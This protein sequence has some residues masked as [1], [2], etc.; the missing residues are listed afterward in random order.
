MIDFSK[1]PRLKTLCVD[2]RSFYASCAAV[3]LGLDPL[4][5]HLAVVSDTQRQGSVVLAASP[6]MKRDFRIKTGSRLFEIPKDPR[7]KVVNASMESFLKTSVGITK[8]LNTFAPR[9]DIHVYSVDEA[10]CVMENNHL[11]GT[12]DEAAKK[13]QDQILKVYG[14]PS[15]IGIGDNMLQSK[16]CLDL[17]SKKSSS[18]IASWTYED[19]PKKLWPVEP[20]SEM[21]G[22]GSRLERRLNRMGIFSVGRLAN[23]PIDLLKKQFGVM[24]EQLY[25]H[26]NGVD[27]SEPGE[28]IMQRQISYGKSQILLRDYG[29]E[30][31]KIPLL[32]ICEEVGR[33]A[34]RAK[35][36]GRTLSLGIGYSVSDNGRGGF[37]HA[38]TLNQPT[39]ITKVI[40]QTFLD[41]FKRYDNG[42]RVRQISVTLSNVSEDRGVQLDLFQPNL[43]KEHALGYVMDKVREKYGSASLLRAV[44]YMPG[45][46]ALERSKLVGGHK[47]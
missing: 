12:P 44:S 41:Q 27:L 26:A 37:H 11:W 4:K 22:I 14:I 35:K 45:G 46:T 19:I 34:R 23:F 36:S 30:E 42:Q 20:L 1:F 5:V 2:M 38:V 29:T 7:I 32:G 24:G 39:N 33:R 21:W 10:F 3:N 28:P 8:L 6:R 40:Y 43:M 47:A 18:G 25:W 16:L 17:N 15:T 9:E 31:A 13:I